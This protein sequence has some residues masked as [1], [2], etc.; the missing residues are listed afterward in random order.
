VSEAEVIHV[1]QETWRGIFNR[2]RREGM[3]FKQIYPHENFN[4]WDML[5]TLTQNILSDFRVAHKQKQLNKNWKDVLHF[6]WMQSRGTYTGYHQ[7]GPLTWKLK[8]SFYY[9]RSL[10][11]TRSVDQKRKVSPIDYTSHPGEKI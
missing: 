8:K 3:A 6:R 2:Y 9:P 10:N 4:T 11:D 7:S 5:H 1:H